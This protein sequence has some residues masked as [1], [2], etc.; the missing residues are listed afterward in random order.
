MVDLHTHV[1]PGM[2]DGARTATESLRMLSD[3]KS[4]GVDLC[5]ATPHFVLHKKNDIDAFLHR[6]RECFL[7]LS[8][9]AE[10]S[11]LPL[12][13]LLL[14]AEVYLDNDINTYADIGK[15]CIGDTPYILVEFPAE[16]YNPYWGDWL[17]SMTLHGLCPVV[18]HIDRYTHIDKMLSDFEGLSI[19]YQVNA[20]RMLSFYG[21]RFIT[22]I[23]KQDIPCIFSS[24]M[25]NLT[26]RKCNMKEAFRKAKKKFPQDA[27]ALFS[28]RAKK[29]L[30]HKEM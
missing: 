17:H 5:A 25:H 29:M 9:A 15:L 4:Q 23:L 3:A 14:G 8:E 28:M 16:K 20:S 2:D 27:A 7:H 24:D 19:T 13:T 11:N 21:R 6:R 18:A 12:P 1:L 22:K 10:K 26:D 30:R